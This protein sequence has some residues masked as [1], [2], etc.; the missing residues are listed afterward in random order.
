M[1]DTLEPA[2]I[3]ANRFR[4][5]QEAAQGN[6]H[7]IDLTPSPEDATV[8]LLSGQGSDEINVAGRSFRPDHRRAFHLPQKLVTPELLTVGGFYVAPIS[9]RDALQ[10]VGSAVNAMPDCKERRPLS[11]RR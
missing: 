7:A 9:K 10:D 4:A 2:A 11:P 1:T 8:R 5:A 3:I 6:P